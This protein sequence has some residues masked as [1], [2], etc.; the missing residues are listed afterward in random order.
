MD[1]AYIWNQMI[2]RLRTPF[3]R[4]YHKH[5][6]IVVNLSSFGIQIFLE[7]CTTKIIY[8]TTN[9]YAHM[10]KESTIKLKKFVILLQLTQ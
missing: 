4:Y 10:T 2:K 1:S 8:M 6:N 3:M 5:E 7:I 9:K